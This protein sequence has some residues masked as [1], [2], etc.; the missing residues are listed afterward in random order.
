MKKLLL[1]LLCFIISIA[2]VTAADILMPVE[3]VVIL[4]S[5]HEQPVKTLLESMGHTVTVV[6]ST[7]IGTI[8]YYDYDAIVI[9]GPSAYEELRSY[10]ENIPTTSHNT[11]AI[12]PHYLDEWGWSNYN[13]QKIMTYFGQNINYN[14]QGYGIVDSMSPSDAVQ[15]PKKELIGIKKSYTTMTSL[16]ENSLSTTSGVIMLAE[17]GT[18]LPNSLQAGGNLLFFGISYPGYWTTETQD[19]FENSME[20]LL[21]GDDPPV[22]TLLTPPN[23][24]HMISGERY[25]FVDFFFNVTDDNSPTLQC[26]MF[27]NMYNSFGNP[28]KDFIAFGAPKTVNNS[29]TESLFPG[30]QTRDDEIIW[31]IRCNDGTS[32]AF[33]SENFTFSIEF[34]ECDTDPDCD[35]GLF[36]NG[37]E[38]CDGNNECQSGVAPDTEDNISCTTDTCDETTDSILHTPTNSL[39]DNGLFCD[40]Q[41]V[42]DPE[43]DCLAG[44]PPVF[45]DGVGC[46]VDSCDEVN[47]VVINSPNDAICDNSLF[48]DGQEFCDLLLDCQDADPVDCDD[49]NTET[50]D[51]CDEDND[52]CIYLEAS[53][54]DDSD[55]DDGLFCNGAEYCNANNEC[56]PGTTVDCSGSD[57]P[58]I[59]TC[60]YDPDNNTDTWDYADSIAAVCSEEQDACIIEDNYNL[61][62]ECDIENC[63]AK[64]IND[65]VC[66]D[67]ECGGSCVNGTYFVCDDVANTCDNCGCTQNECAEPSTCTPSGTDNDNDTVDNECND[68]CP[69]TANPDQ[70]DTDGDGMG[71]ACD[72]F[73]NDFD[74]DGID[75]ENDTLTGDVDDV[76][77]SGSD[78]ENL[79]IEINGSENLT[80]IFSG[81]LPVV[82][83]EASDTIIEFTFDFDNVLD[84]SNIEIITNDDSDDN[85]FIIIKGLD[86]GDGTKTVYLNKKLEDA[87]RI[88]IIDDEI[89]S[90]SEMSDDCSEDDELALECDGTETQGY[91]CTLINETTYKIEGLQHSA[92]Q[93]YKKNTAPQL[94]KRGGGGG[95]GGGGSRVV[96]PEPQ[97]DQKPA[98]VPYV[99][100]PQVEEEV[101]QDVVELSESEDNNSE[102]Y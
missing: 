69:D 65:S 54:E 17:R 95:G 39:C 94:K 29:A 42:C 91:S 80:Q 47:D 79:T 101:V 100:I 37:E 31:N 51:I 62:H 59:E 5:V 55:C 36:C 15:D 88:C 38:Y 16:A 63:G 72:A 60:T 97:V 58:A 50:D 61:T 96:D 93:E 84:I 1:L 19:M 53:C 71:D 82:F 57:L 22:V 21:T 46:T 33:A 8:N 85:A 52:V 49:N 102:D 81:E 20:W 86:L 41:E 10:L 7:T 13:S 23:G 4:D 12:Y 75:D 90:I 56:Q 68:N 87:D 32:E 40:G 43:L 28:T 25:E 78:I 66:P 67:T 27:C 83:R 76:D 77:L 2:S 92:V 48:C 73:P 26:Q 74:N 99:S 45:D 14:D 18:T 6:D 24:T 30:T 3:R 11:L 70:I 35:D 98:L 34:K 64:C 44:T 89:A 9:P